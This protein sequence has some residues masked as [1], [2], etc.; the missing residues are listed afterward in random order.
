MTTVFERILDE[1]LKLGHGPNELRARTWFRDRAGNV[2]RVQTNKMVTESQRYTNKP[3][4]GH[5]ILFQY[6][7]LLKESLPYW[8]AFPLV[9][10]FYEDATSFTGINMH[11]LPPKMRAKLMDALYNIANNNKFDRTTKLK[12]TYDLLNSSAQ[13]KLFKPCIRQ[14]LKTHVRSRL[15]R[16]NANEWDIAL[17]LPIARFKKQRQDAIWADTR[18]KV[19]KL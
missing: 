11:Y 12:M 5:M 10:P 7:P 9:F 17:F 2:Q 18:K 8:D 19:R 6:D 3:S 1:G 4:V 13:F 14:Y 15:I 16:I